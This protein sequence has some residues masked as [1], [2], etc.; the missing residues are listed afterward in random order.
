[1]K[2]LRYF[3]DNFEKIRL[4]AVRGI[5]SLFSARD[6]L[7]VLEQE[8]ESSV[9]SKPHPDRLALAD[10]TEPNQVAMWTTGDGGRIQVGYMTDAHLFYALAKAGRGEYPDT[11]SRATGVRVLKIEAFRR[12]R[13]ELTKPPV[14]S[15]AMKSWSKRRAFDCSWCVGTRSSHSTTCPTLSNP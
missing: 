6:A 8:F 7:N 1:M 10:L 12:L 15:P 3:V 2:N 14:D 4:D 11:A 9:K 13:N 5:T